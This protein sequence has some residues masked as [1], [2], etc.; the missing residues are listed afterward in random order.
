[1]YGRHGPVIVHAKPVDDTDVAL[2][3]HTRSSFAD[4]LRIQCCKKINRGALAIIPSS[5]TIQRNRRD[6]FGFQILRRASRGPL[7]TFRNKRIMIRQN[8]KSHEFADS[9]ERAPQTFRLGFSSIRSPAA[10]QASHPA[11][12]ARARS[13]PARFRSCAARALV[14]SSGQAQNAMIQVWRGTLSSAIR[15]TIWSAGIRNAP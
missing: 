13:H 14:A 9:R 1:M 4:D 15:R 8:T 3:F 12:S 11:I 6:I 7:G 2:S 10:C 5:A